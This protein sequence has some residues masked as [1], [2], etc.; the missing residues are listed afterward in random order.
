[1][2]ETHPIV[3]VSEEILLRRELGARDGASLCRDFAVVFVGIV[4]LVAALVLAWG[5]AWYL[6]AREQFS[7][8]L[9]ILLLCGLAVLTPLL[10]WQL[11]YVLR[12]TRFCPGIVGREVM[13]PG[14]YESS[15][16]MKSKKLQLA[17]SAMEVRR[18]GVARLY[19]VQL[20][21]G[22]ERFSIAGLTKLESEV[23]RLYHQASN[24]AI[25][26]SNPEGLSELPE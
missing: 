19:M 14:E 18:S 8:S 7:G 12:F 9:L 13:R 15:F 23:V 21:C 24:P 17:G 2:S 1:V 11:S 22:H 26:A 25:G 5:G 10:V 6:L 16:W 20:T 3:S 4:P